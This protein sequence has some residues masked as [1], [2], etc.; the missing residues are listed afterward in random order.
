MM[1]LDVC[2]FAAMGLVASLGAC[3]SPPAADSRP[4]L[5]SQEEAR[6]VVDRLMAEW[7][8]GVVAGD[9]EA[10]AAQYADDAV[11]MEPGRAALVGREAI[12]SWLQSQY[13]RFTF[14][15]TNEIDEVLVL[16]PEWILVRTHG[17]F[18]ATPKAGGEILESSEKWL[19]LLERQPDGS[20]KF[21]RDCGGS[22]LQEPGK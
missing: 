16:G 22:D 3:T 12:L 8:A 21:F 7:D 15:G 14:Q 9:L 1:K 18:T 20:W 11:R 13:D 5:L 4:E 10:A 2:I 6:A 19:G 17:E